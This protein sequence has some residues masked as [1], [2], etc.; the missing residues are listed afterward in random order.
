[1]SSHVLV[2]SQSAEFIP[3]PHWEREKPLLTVESVCHGDFEPC[4][5][6]VQEYFALV[7]NGREFC[8]L[9]FTVPSRADACTDG[10][11]Y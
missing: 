8:A 1:V 7:S 6:L 11:D 10:T 5:G 9:K 3:P 4:K 2:S